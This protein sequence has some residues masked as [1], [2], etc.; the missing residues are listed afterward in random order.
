[1]SGRSKRIDEGKRRCGARRSTF[2]P[3]RSLPLAHHLPG[4]TQLII[5]YLFSMTLAFSEPISS[6][7]EQSQA[8]QAAV[9]VMGIDAAS[10]DSSLCL[11]CTINPIDYQAPGCKHPSLCKK[12]AMRQAT[13]GKCKVGSTARAEGG[14]TRAHC[15]VARLHFVL[16]GVRREVL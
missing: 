13:G 12:C 14:E 16:T 15:L 6:P 4:S 3:H 11:N 8:S 2:S 7:S 5:H 9:S 1:M 10:S